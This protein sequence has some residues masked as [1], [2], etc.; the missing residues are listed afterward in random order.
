MWTMGR[1][2]VSPSGLYDLHKLDVKFSSVAYGVALVFRGS[3]DLGP[4]GR[5]GDTIVC[6]QDTDHTDLFRSYRWND[7]RWRVCG[8]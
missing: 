8:R 3:I 6:D 1:V 2:Q 7:Y 5:V 4:L